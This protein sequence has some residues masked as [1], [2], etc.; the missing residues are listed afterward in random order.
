MVLA[1]CPSLSLHRSALTSTYGLK[2]RARLGSPPRTRDCQRSHLQ[3]SGALLEC[4]QEGALENFGESELQGWAAE[5]TCAILASFPGRTYVLRT[6]RSA[7]FHVAWRLVEYPGIINSFDDDTPKY[8]AGQLTNQH[9]NNSILVG[10][11]TSVIR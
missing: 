9:D 8:T 5:I 3:Q 7:A 10:K 4:T 6:G 2:V 11:I 1:L